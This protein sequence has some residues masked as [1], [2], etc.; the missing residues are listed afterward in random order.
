MKKWIAGLLITFLAASLT[1]C[2]ERAEQAAD[3]RN[4]KMDRD[5]IFDGTIFEGTP[6]SENQLIY[7]REKR[8]R[9]N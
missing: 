8:W 3:L 6:I 2:K 5:T 7:R 1:A 9:G 4:V